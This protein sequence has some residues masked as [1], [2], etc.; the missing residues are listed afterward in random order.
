MR[1]LVLCAATAL[2]AAAPARAQPALV[3]GAALPQSGMLVDLAADLGK[4]LLLWQEEVNARGGLLGRQVSLRLLDDGSS[5]AAAGA[6]YGKLIVE[7]RAELLVGPFGSAASLGAAGAAERARRVLVNATGASRLVHR[8]GL[9]YVFQVPA[10]LGG[11]GGGALEL[12]RRQGLQRVVLLARDEPVAREMAFRAREDAGRLGLT[13][14]GLVLHSSSVTDFSPHIE[15]ARGARAQAW[16]AF[17]QVRDAAEMVKSFKRLGYAPA[18][19]VA[20]GA[21][22]PDFIVRVGQDAE[23][24]IGISPYQTRAATQGNADFVRAF[25]RKWSAEPG[26]LAA[27]GYA[28]AKV[29]EAAVRHA[30]SLDQ[31]QLREALAALRLETPLGPYRVGEGGEQLAA[32]PLLVQVLEGRR[33][34][35]WPEALATARWRLPYPPW[36]E[37]K[38]LP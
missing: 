37:R 21:A 24:A 10:P 29:L 23:Q 1:A 4:A 26:A 34:I 28:A 8:A 20:Q 27:Q 6:L 15:R 14:T 12:A 16:I 33:E 9:R 35:V 13:V 25:A 30:G 18:L 17:G 5:A 38:L 36:E 32:R 19:F 2:I 11:Y 3:V 31:E 22:E 7:H